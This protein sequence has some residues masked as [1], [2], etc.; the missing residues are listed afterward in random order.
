MD[1]LD[2]MILREMEI[3]GRQSVSDLSKKLGISRAYAGKKL[4]RLLDLR[5]TR[6]AAFTKP[7][8]LGYRTYAIIGIK[9]S[10]NQLD[11]TADKLRALVSVHQVAIVAGR[12]DILITIL[13][14]T[15]EDLPIFLQRKLGSIPSITSVETNIVVETRKM[16]FS[17][18]KSTQLGEKVSHRNEN[19]TSIQ[20]G[21]HNSDVG[22]DDVDLQ[23]LRELESD[24]RQSVSDMARKLG[25]NRAHASARL[26]RLLDHQVTRVVAFN[27]P[28]LLGYRT[29]A[30]I[31]IKV[32]PKKINTVAD[33]L[34]A[35]TDV[36][37]V[38]MVAGR[39]DIF[40]YT[41]FPDPR[42]LSMFLGREL[43]SI[44]GITSIE[45]VIGLEQRKMSLH[46]LAS[47]HL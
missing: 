43:G 9:V 40:I 30:M 3:D 25:I 10:P 34:C 36:Y 2:L 1:Q 44:S 6:I 42:E 35:M 13:L 22:I 45:V 41:M 17:Y 31:G 19:N 38:V 46:R 39:H 8:A 7:L 47:S 15:P 16:S 23:I 4:K 12:Y 14:K 20:Q 5:L 11:A 28:L 26:Q 37:W 29:F 33:R 21:A 27:N 18:L 32:S 24:G